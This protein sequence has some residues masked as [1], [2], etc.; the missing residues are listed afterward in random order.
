MNLDLFNNNANTNDNFITKF[1]EELK[2]ALENI[3]SI[4][5]KEDTDENILNETENATSMSVLDEYNLYEKRKIYLDNV[6]YNENDI[7]W[8]MEENI[9]C[10]SKHGDG[11]LYGINEVDFELPENAKAGEVYEKIDGKY[12][13]NM[14][15]TIAVSNITLDTEI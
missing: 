10:V 15:L 11:G 3:I 7:I 2:E 9:I 13:L 5:K 4:V 6:S 8:Y 12:V 1:I 14:D